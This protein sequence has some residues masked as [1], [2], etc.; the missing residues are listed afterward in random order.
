MKM[1]NNSFV[2]KMP[3]KLC[4]CLTYLFKKMVDV[5][6]SHT[7][8]VQRSPV[9]DPDKLGLFCLVFLEPENTIFVCN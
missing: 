9:T 6:C 1:I 4:K 5:F 3:N 8:Q 7:G 2:K